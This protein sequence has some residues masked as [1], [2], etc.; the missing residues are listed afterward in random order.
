MDRGVE[1]RGDVL[2]ILYVGQC[3]PLKAVV[4]G[5][6]MGSVAL[7]ALCNSAAGLRRRGPHLAVNALIYAAAT[8]WEYL[9]PQHHLA[10]RRSEAVEY[11]NRPLSKAA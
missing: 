9:H 4:H 7:C 11:G 8:A 3:E 6:L 10:C 5:V 1:R 2:E